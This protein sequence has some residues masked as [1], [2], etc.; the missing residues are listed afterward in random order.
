MADDEPNLYREPADTLRVELEYLQARLR[1]E[2]AE[3]NRY[4]AMASK[5]DE[6]LRKLIENAEEDAAMT[7]SLVK[8]YRA[9]IKRVDR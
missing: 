8:D 4:K 5:R 1:E 7:A 6:G 9:A 2:R 3:V